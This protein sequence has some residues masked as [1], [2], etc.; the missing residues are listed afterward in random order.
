MA[1]N[2]RSLFVVNEE[3]LKWVEV[4]GKDSQKGT[5]TKMVE[6]EGGNN[7]LKFKLCGPNQAS[8]SAVCLGSSSGP[9]CWP[10]HSLWSTELY[11]FT[12]LI[13][14]GYSS[15]NPLAAVF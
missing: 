7:L 10:L 1:W 11:R 12:R 15:P 5:C 3:I 14:G 8:H 4:E 9:T 13:P 2:T 6:M